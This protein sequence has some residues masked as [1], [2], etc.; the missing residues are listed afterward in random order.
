MGMRLLKAFVIACAGSVALLAEAPGQRGIEAGDIDRNARPCTDFHQYANG[1]W[2]AANPI[3]PSMGS[4]SRRWQAGEQNKDQLKTI[5]D[6]LSKRKDW[7]KGSV[8]QLIT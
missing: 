6:D 2:R 4:W 8:E 5:L 7:P 1:A 3:P